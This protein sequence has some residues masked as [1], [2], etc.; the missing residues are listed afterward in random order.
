MDLG[1]DKNTTS[2]TTI[3][4]AIFRPKDQSINPWS[5]QINL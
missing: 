3:L 1:E 2:D 4:Q 5:S